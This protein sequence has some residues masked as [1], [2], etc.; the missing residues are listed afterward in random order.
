MRLAFLALA[1]LA[2]TSNANGAEVLPNCYK[3][4]SVETP[5]LHSTVLLVD[6]NVVY[7]FKA[8]KT[9]N[10]LL[11]SLKGNEMLLLVS[12][13]KAKLDI[14]LLGIV[15]SSGD[16]A[17]DAIDFPTEFSKSSYF[18]CLKKSKFE[19]PQK[20]RIAMARL[21]PFE[22]EEGSM[23]DDHLQVLT[24]LLSQYVASNAAGFTLYWFSDGSVDSDQFKQVEAQL[25]YPE[26]VVDEISAKGLA[27]PA[28]P[29]DSK[30]IMYSKMS[31]RGER[32]GASWQSYFDAIGVPFERR[33][34]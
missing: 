26:Q 6:Q 28:L 4:S 27:L 15:P 32:E 21:F 20:I 24:A 22:A 2:A 3:R 1:L 33:M 31:Y 29:K 5:S 9:A 12:Y 13:R 17:T 34:Y 25:E 19:Y 11:K 18:R 16:S 14:D 23:G 8:R 30:V 10:E 7:N